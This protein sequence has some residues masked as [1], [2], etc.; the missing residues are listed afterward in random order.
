[1]QKE[2]IKNL[3]AYINCYPIH[4][5]Q[6]QEAINI[7]H[8]HQCIEDPVRFLKEVSKEKS[9]FMTEFKVISIGLKAL[10]SLEEKETSDSSRW[11]VSD[12]LKRIE[13]I[14]S[15]ILTH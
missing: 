5:E 8:K 4:I 14:S 9:L 7:L 12:D 6:K 10:S 1:M 2:L 13:K 15:H 11:L 3:T